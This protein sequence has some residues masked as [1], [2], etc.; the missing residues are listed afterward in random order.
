[1]LLVVGGHT[2][3]IGKTSVVCNVLRA[4][5]DWNW[6]A[7]KIT[8]Y[9]HGVCSRDGEPCECSD[10][11][12][13]IAVSEET[14][15]SPTTDSGRFLASG[16]H[17]AFWV[18]TPAGELNEAIPRIRRL[19]AGAE[20]TI[21]ESNSI[22]RFLKPDLCAMVLDGSVPDFKTTSQRFLDRAGV[23][24]LTSDAPLAW[25]D[26]PAALLRNKPRFTA[27][28]PRYENAQ[29]IDM[30]RQTALKLSALTADHTHR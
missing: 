21:I 3:N 11:V 12:H 23:L 8:Q 29:F 20:H 28:P 24:V 13:P 6:T 30:I 16:A 18:R 26:V 1:M 27:L 22:L 10:P 5:P 17:R 2:R 4:L 14:G 7:I 25:P 15:L 9:G 19:I